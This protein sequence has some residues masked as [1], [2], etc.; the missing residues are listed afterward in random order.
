MS[1]LSVHP[2]VPAAAAPAAALARPRTPLGAAL[3]GAGVLVRA[4]FEVVVLG[5]ADE[6][7]LVRRR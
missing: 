1:S 5:R 2:T 6:D 3:H 4:A 7:G